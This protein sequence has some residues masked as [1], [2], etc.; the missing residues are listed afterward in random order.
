VSQPLRV[1]GE[2]A[3]ERR[4]AIDAVGAV[5]LMD[6]TVLAEGRG[7]FLRLPEASA[8]AMVADYPEFVNY[9]QT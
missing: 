9:W 1:W 7:M 6:G 5:E 8:T 4:G 2:I 3:R